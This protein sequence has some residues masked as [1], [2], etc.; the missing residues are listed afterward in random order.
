MALG[1][2]KAPERKKRAE[3]RRCSA[4]QVSL[5]VTTVEKIRFEN[6]LGAHLNFVQR[7]FK[8][9]ECVRNRNKESKLRTGSRLA[10]VCQICL[11]WR[12]GSYPTRSL[13]NFYI[14]YNIEPLNKTSLVSLSVDRTFYVKADSGKTTVPVCFICLSAVPGHK[15][16]YYEMRLISVGI[17]S[18]C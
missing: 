13:C 7:L 11:L 1:L 16:G 18:I 3:E 10:Q 6:E 15:A 12:D 8:V 17:L 9:L 4:N 2:R 14:V 5:K